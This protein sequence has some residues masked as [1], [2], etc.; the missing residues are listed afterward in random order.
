MEELTKQDKSVMVLVGD[1][2]FSFFERFA[3]KYPKQ[4][5]NAGCAEQN[6]ILAAEGLALAGKKPYVYSGIIFY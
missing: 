1:L 4:F 5:I 3:E 6:M 2:G